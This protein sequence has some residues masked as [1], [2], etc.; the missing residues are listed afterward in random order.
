MNLTDCMS[1][2]HM[3]VGETE[4]IWFLFAAHLNE[5]KKNGNICIHTKTPSRSRNVQRICE[6]DFCKY[7]FLFV[8]QSD[9]FKPGLVWKRRKY[10]TIHH[11]IL[12]TM[13]RLVSIHLLA[14]NLC[15]PLGQFPPASGD[16]HG[17]GQ[18]DKV[19]DQSGHKTL[20][21][22]LQKGL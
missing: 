6:R 19:H 22:H 5:S 4:I 3:E 9:L 14:W 1:T 18:Q 21:I 13:R 17:R 12:V 2:S 11:P 15:E 10:L 20:T 8:R 16:L 7:Y